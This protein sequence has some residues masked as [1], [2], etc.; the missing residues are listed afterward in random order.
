MKLSNRRDV[1]KRREQH[2]RHMFLHAYALGS[3]RIGQR[4][5]FTG[6]FTQW[7][8]EEAKRLAVQ[9]DRQ[10]HRDEGDKMK[11]QWGREALRRGSS[12]CTPPDQV[13]EVRDSTICQGL[14]V[15]ATQDISKGDY[16]TSYPTKPIGLLM[17]LGRMTT[18]T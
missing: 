11:E 18:V 9:P 8:Q 14:G 7:G 4:T 3:L 2:S 15:F 10:A 1:I 6:F 17:G 12:Q 13:C 16:I 5:M